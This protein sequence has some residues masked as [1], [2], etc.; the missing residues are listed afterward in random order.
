M[1]D[2]VRRT[3]L[4]VPTPLDGYFRPVIDRAAAVFADR[5]VTA[6]LLRM[7]TRWL[8]SGGTQIGLGVPNK[9]FEKWEALYRAC[10]QWP[11]DAALGRRPP[12]PPGVYLPRTKRELFLRA[13]IHV[14]AADSPRFVSTIQQ[15]IMDGIARRP[16][17]ATP[18][19]REYYAEKT[20][21]KITLP[22]ADWLRKRL[23]DTC[24]K[25]YGQRTAQNL[26]SLERAILGVAVT[27]GLDDAI[28]R[29]RDNPDALRELNERIAAVINPSND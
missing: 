24:V 4:L 29:S 1:E 18:S 8:P 9:L 22:G 2:F 12:V 26:A 6:A 28:A 19:Q 23:A 21:Q 10:E 13:A 14:L 25:R 17:V 7:D 27:T 15:Q 3:S 16:S 20:G 5:A 11:A